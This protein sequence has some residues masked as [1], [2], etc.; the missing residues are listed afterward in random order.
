MDEKSSADEEDRQ[1]KHASAEPVEVEF[2]MD[3]I[4]SIW[5]SHFGHSKGLIHVVFVIGLSHP[6][7][8]KLFH[9]LDFLFSSG[10]WRNSFF[11][12]HFDEC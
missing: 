6:I 5:I 7:L 11:E 1:E 2:M 8:P 9:S 4:H 12:S 3:F 10:W